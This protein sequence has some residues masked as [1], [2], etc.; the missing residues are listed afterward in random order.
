[1]YATSN[2][3]VQAA[4]QLGYNLVTAHII[5]RVQPTGFLDNQSAAVIVPGLPFINPLRLLVGPLPYIVS[6]S[7]LVLK[8]GAIHRRARQSID[9][10]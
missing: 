9:S 4:R 3:N 10:F 8:I 2:V 6:V 5:P 7:E 1:M